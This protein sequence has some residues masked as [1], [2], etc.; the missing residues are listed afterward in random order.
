MK[1][2]PVVL[3][4]LAAGCAPKPAVQVPVTAAAPPEPVGLVSYDGSYDGLGAL[5]RGDPMACG[6]QRLIPIRVQND[7]L[8][9]VLRQPQIRWRPLI[10]FQA[11][12]A[13]DGT[14]EAVDG[15]NYIRGSISNGH[16]QGDL[17]GDACSHSFQAD[18]SGTW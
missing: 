1:H 8:T 15:P 13:A 18:R 2:L 12:V 7:V 3:L 6:T 10:T 9:Y 14:F 5:T 4:L 11:P 17:R 16:M